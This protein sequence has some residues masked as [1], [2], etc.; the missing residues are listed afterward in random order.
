M[1]AQREEGSDSGGQGEGP[2]EKAGE[3]PPPGLQRWGPAHLL[4]S[5]SEG[6]Q[7]G[8]GTPTVSLHPRH[9]GLRVAQTDGPG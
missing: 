7:D 2:R 9:G 4:H 1:G 8:R 6:P 3:P 5:G